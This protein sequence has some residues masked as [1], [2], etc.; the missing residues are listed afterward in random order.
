MYNLRVALSWVMRQIRGVPICMYTYV[1]MLCRESGHP[2]SRR[3]KLSKRFEKD[4]PH[5]AGA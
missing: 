4:D 3:H 2:I 5:T 1:C